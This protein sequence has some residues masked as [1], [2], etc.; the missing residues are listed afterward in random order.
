[1]SPHRYSRGTIALHW[2]TV[3]LIILVYC[4]MEFRGLFERGSPERDLVKS[5]H[6][7][8]GLLVLGLT[9][10]RIY[11]RSRQS[12]PPIEPVPAPW[13]HKLAAL[14]HLALYMLLL[15]MPLLGWLIL[16]AEGKVVP[17]FGLQLPALV[18]TDP[19]VA[20]WAEEL[21]ELIAQAGYALIGLHAIAALWH[22]YG[23]RDNTL[24]RMKW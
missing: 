11:W 2:I 12:Y 19:Q 3:L 14:V 17:F 18:A 5:V 22:H 23:K 15:V 6:Y 7:M 8:A 24:L 10:L 13:Q 1:M 4:T 21:H 9:V 16:S 20:E